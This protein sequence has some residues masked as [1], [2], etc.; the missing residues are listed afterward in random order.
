MFDAVKAKNDCVQWIR[1]WFDANGK[2]CNA[3]IGISGGKDSTVVAALCVEALGKNRVYGIMMPNGYQVDIADSKKVCDFLHIHK[4]ETDI[5]KA[6]DAIMN[7]IGWAV[8]GMSELKS[9]VSEQTKVNLAPR[10]RM[11]TLYAIS[12]SL[13]GRVVGT[14][15]ASEAYIGYST[16]WGDNVADL[17]PIL[18]FTSEEVVAIG[19][20]LG[21]PYE[22]TH[23]TPS[24][25]LCGK[26]DEDNFGFTYEALNK[27]ILTG[28]CE[29]EEVKAKIDNL[30]KK[31]LFK[32]QS[33]P[34]FVPMGV[35]S[36][37]I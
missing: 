9:T 2:D 29:D 33:I 19:D 8:C 1:D 31:N 17:M 10:I 16:R 5:K 22:L 25:G 12:Q 18:N 3:I 7:E 21:L 26:T 28:E 4:W 36:D 35:R 6:Y 27:Y 32:T 14:D 20:A 34:S 30:H 11:A 15:N 37:D 13:N 23:K 24:D